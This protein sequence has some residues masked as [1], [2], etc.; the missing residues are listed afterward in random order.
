[1]SE[2]IV[3]QLYLS[4]EWGQLRN[5]LIIECKSTCQRCNKYYRD[6][7]KLIGHHKIHLT[8]EN[9]HDYNISLNKDN[10]ELICHDCHNKE[11]K[12]FGYKDHKVYIVYGP[13]LA[14]KKVLVNQLSERG[15]LIIDIDRI[16]ECISGQE[17]YNKPNNLRFNVFA[18]RDKLI[19]MVKTRYGQWQ[20]AYI[21][22]GYPDKNERE[23]LA[24]ELRAELIYCE[25]TKEECYK[26]VRDTNKDEEWYGF[27][28]K[29]WDNYTV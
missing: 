4:K 18:V 22:G 19:D 17:L 7:S 9:V 15:D 20:D 6:T 27:I 8:K 28:D 12:R 21:I 13:P 11:H 3:R 2:G 24:N 14:G 10:V 5:N 29:W 25:S 1:M 23:R 16:Y 26:T